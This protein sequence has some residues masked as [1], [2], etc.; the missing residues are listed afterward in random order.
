MTRF[1]VLT[2]SIMLLSTSAIYAQTSR[3]FNNY[4]ETSTSPLCNMHDNKVVYPDQPLTVVVNYDDNGALTKS[5]SYKTTYKIEYA[6]GGV[7][8]LLIIPG[9]TFETFGTNTPEYTKEEFMDLPDV[10]TLIEK[11]N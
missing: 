8:Y 9:Y 10:K 7:L 2:L 4:K 11:L 6:H 5:G 3:D 1:F